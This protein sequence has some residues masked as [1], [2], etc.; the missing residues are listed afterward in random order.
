MIVFNHI[1]DDSVHIS[2]DVVHTLIRQRKS[3]K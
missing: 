1:S 3:I 2:D